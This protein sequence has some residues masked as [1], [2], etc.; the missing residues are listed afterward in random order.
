MGEDARA[1]GRR[2]KPDYEFAHEVLQ[3]RDP[4]QFKAVGDPTRQKIISLLTEKAATTSQLAEALGQPKGS[5][6]HHLKVLENAGLIRVVRTR[7]VRAIT[8]KYYGRTARLFDFREVEGVPGVEPF[9][10]LREAINEYVL[11]ESVDGFEDVSTLAHA[12]IPMEKAQEFADR[13]MELAEEFR[14]QE[15]V[16]GERVYGFIAGVYLTDLPELP[17]DEE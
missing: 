11:P 4:E 9:F 7:Q 1:G 10:L 2:A 17:R 8:E 6:G 12:R 5:I 16:P 14:T 15:S 3:V 13:V